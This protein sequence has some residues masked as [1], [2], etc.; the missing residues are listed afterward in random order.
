MTY[1]SLY[2]F[3]PFVVA[4]CIQLLKV[5]IDFYFK[6]RKVTIQSFIGSG[7]FPST[8]AALST[9][10]IVVLMLHFQRDSP[11]VMMACVYAFLIWYDALSVR[12]EAGKHALYI[13]TLR[14][15]L[16]G[17][18]WD[19]VESSEHEILKERIGHTFIEVIGGIVL[20][21]FLSL[22]FYLFWLYGGTVF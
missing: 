11:Y 17:L 4:A 15:Q 20:W 14:H 21:W 6:E 2:F 1:Q 3:I 16:R 8:H 7:G 18:L 5:F 22:V 19:D 13:N 9:S 10:V 12:Y